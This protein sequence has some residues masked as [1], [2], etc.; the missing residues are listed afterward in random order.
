MKNIEHQNL[1]YE[2]KHERI[3][4]EDVCFTKEYVDFEL[5]PNIKEFHSN[6]LSKQC[7]ESALRV[8]LFQCKI[9]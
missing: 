3:Y 5:F 7:S 1:K 4:I 8:N 6:S 2:I 9:L